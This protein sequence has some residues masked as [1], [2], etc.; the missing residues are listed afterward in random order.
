MPHGRKRLVAALAAIA[1]LIGL[2]LIPATPTYADPSIDSVQKKV[3]KLL[4]EAELA[5]E[6]ANDIQ[7]QLTGMRE[8]LATLQA[9][10]IR[11]DRPNIGGDP[12]LNLGIRTSESLPR[13][14]AIGPE[15]DG[16]H[17]ISLSGLHTTSELDTA[18]V[19]AIAGLVK[20]LTPNTPE[21]PAE[22]ADP[23]D[24]TESIESIPPTE[25]TTDSEVGETTPENNE[26]DSQG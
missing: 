3:D 24:S 10:D 1:A 14:L 4:H 13:Y 9:D 25:P 5:A 8:D 2:G 6:N 15:E 16:H 20:D 22:P 11:T 18:A 17:L 23:T 26:A 12:I 21:A 19:A 7:I